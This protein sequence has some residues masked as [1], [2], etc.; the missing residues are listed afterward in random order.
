MTRGQRRGW[1]AAALAAVAVSPSGP[2]WAEEPPAQTQVAQVAPIPAP[3]PSPRDLIS[4]D[5]KEADL[6]SVLRALAQKAR[7]NIVTTRGVAGSVTIRLDDVPWETAL[8]VILKTSDLGYERDGNVITVMPADELL[9]QH[10]LQREMA[11]QEPLVSKVIVLKFLDADDVK[12]FLQP[13]LSAQG[14]ISVLEVTGQRGW[15]F[16]TAQAKKSEKPKERAARGAA[17]SKAVLITDTPSTLRRMEAILDRV[18]VKP[19]QIII[20]TRIMEVDRDL[21]RDVGVDF[22]T[23]STGASSST[24]TLSPAA[25]RNGTSIAS[26]GLHTLTG[27]VTPSTFLPKTSAITTDNTGFKFEFQRLTGMQ[28][29]VIIRALE[30]DARTNTLSA[31]Q[32]I[33]L[34]G[35]EASI[36]VGTKYPILETQVSGTSVTTTT[37]SLDYYQDIGI[38]LY[39]VPQ[40]GGDQ[41]ID[42]IIHPVVSSF[43]S[44]VG[45]NAYPIIT[46]REAETQMVIEDGDTV[47]LGGLLKDVKSRDRVGLPFLGKIPLLGLLFSRASTDVEKIDLLIFI[48]ARI[49]RFDQF[50]P[51][52]L[53]ALKA[54]YDTSIP[55][56]GSGGA[57]GPAAPSTKK[58]PSKGPPSRR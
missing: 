37:T 22:G 30:E 47:V 31:P 35:Q 44:T 19:T 12:K 51:E 39:V 20:E 50:T 29:D 14:R 53:A 8:D 40:V 57:R 36:L 24:L 9:R 42:V 41:Y 10:E 23:G 33:T 18:D 54:K 32:I 15:Q 45:S 55:V 17:R 58:K 3:A 27:L 48:T 13:Q 11:A 46:T 4:L 56:E 7:V 26:F 43:S 6:Q 5:F 38:Q 25:K 2:A 28:F 49:V 1:A 16:G 21:V 34:N 52:E